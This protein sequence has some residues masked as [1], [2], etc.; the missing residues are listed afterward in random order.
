V[1]PIEKRG[2]LFDLQRLSLQDGPG[3]RTCVFFK[4]CPLRC[5]W[6]HN[7]ESLESRPQL[8]YTDR[9]CAG[10]GACMAACPNRAHGFDQAGRH[11]VDFDRCNA[12][13]QCLKVCC[14]GALR[15]AG[16]RATVQELLDELQPD[17]PY[18]AKPDARG[19]TGGVTLTG[20]EPMAQFAFVQ[21][22][23][24]AKGNLSVWMETCG[25][26]P[27]HKLLGIAPKVDGFLYDY[28]A[29]DPAVHKRLCGVDNA[30]ILKNLDALAEAGARIVLRLPLVPGVNDG[31]EHLRGIASL[32]ERYP[33]IERAEIMPY[34]RLGV[35][36]AEQAGMA[37]PGVDQPNATAADEERWLKRLHDLGAMRVTRNGES[38]QQ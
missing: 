16:R 25:H 11:T 14:Y 26:G 34:H 24:A 17:L 2:V 7:P 35:A 38:R 18:F 8:I 21:E 28:K 20:G 31:D 3:I 32:L 4:G 22:F 33:G 29:T 37:N 36:K 30:L 12:C 19:E 10:C 1:L 15:V 6:C 27:T 23:L 13:G 5:A 9:L